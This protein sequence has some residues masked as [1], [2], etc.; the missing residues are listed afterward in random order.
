MSF[1]E[2]AGLTKTFKAD[3]LVTEVINGLD[4]KVEKGDIAIVSGP[5]GCGKTTLLNILGGTEPP[6]QGSVVVDGSDVW[7]MGKDEIVNYRRHT[8][9]FVFQF[10]N[11]LPTLTA[12]ENIE[13]GLETLGHSKAL[14]ESLAMEYLEIV[15]LADKADS[16]PPQLSGGQ[17]QRVSIARALA[18]TPKVVLADEPTG[19]LDEASSVEVMELIKRLNEER[20]ITF[21]IVTHDPTVASYG[22]RLVK[23]VGGK[24]AADENVTP[25]SE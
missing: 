25:G 7:T 11:L 9:G 16:F 8:M 19:N 20:E 4:L 10:Y 23:M 2:I 22:N 14:V 21:I 13:L 24:V 18:K 5:S 17:Q 12:K 6:D 15:G 3:E 1:I